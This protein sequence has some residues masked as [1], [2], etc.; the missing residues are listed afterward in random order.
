MEGEDSDY[1][2]FVFVFFVFFGDIFFW[3]GRIEGGGG[4]K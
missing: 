4:L 3:W 2:W 1:V